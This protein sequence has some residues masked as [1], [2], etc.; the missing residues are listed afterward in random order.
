MKAMSAL[1]KSPDVRYIHGRVAYLEVRRTCAYSAYLHEDG[2]TGPAA[3]LTRWTVSWLRGTLPRLS[4]PRSRSIP[5]GS[6]LRAGRERE[7]SPRRL[8]APGVPAADTGPVERPRGPSRHAPEQHQQEGCGRQVLAEGEGWQPEGRDHGDTQAD[9]DR[10]EELRRQRAPVAAPTT[11]MAHAVPQCRAFTV[12]VAGSAA[13]LAGPPGL[14]VQAQRPLVS[15][16]WTW[17][18]AGKG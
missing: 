17:S 10:V 1:G 13:R 2:M 18:W 7:R 15:W 4:A 3:F 9:R 16:T 8:R 6:S 5:R 14:C 12:L 11:A